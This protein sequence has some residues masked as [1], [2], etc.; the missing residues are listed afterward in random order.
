MCCAYCYS[1]IRSLC[2][3]AAVDDTIRYLSSFRDKRHVFIVFHG[4]EPL[5]YPIENVHAILEYV[6][7]S[8]KYHLNVQFQTNGTLLNRDWLNLFQK[9]QPMLSLSVSIDPSGE[10]DFRFGQNHTLRETVL[11]NIAEA[12]RYVPNTGVISVAHRYNKNS[13]I[14][15]IDE[16]IKLNVHGMTISKLQDPARTLGNAYLNEDEYVNLLMDTG[17]YWI[18]ERLYTRIRL[19]PFSSFFIRGGSRICRYLAEEKKCSLFRTFCSKNVQSDF[20]DHVNK[21]KPPSCPEPCKACDIYQYCGGGCFLEEKDY[22][23]CE[24]RHRLF[25]AIRSIRRIHN[26]NRESKC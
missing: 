4:G 6:F 19:Q 13:F 14:S 21:D 17:Y 24:A 16:L 9:Y 2:G 23:F 5:L 10:K 3:T 8:F 1:H 22:T 26:E 7:S 25:N 15:F 20:C 11:N 18:A 12:A